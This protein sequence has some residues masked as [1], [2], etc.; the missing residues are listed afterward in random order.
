MPLYQYQA[1]DSQGR[2]KKGAIEATG[3]TD[4]KEKLRSQG[5]MVSNVSEQQAGGRANT[6]HGEELVLFTMQLSQLISAGLPLYESINTLEEQYRTERYHRVLLSLSEKVKAGSS[7]S[8][9][10]ADHPQSFDRLYCSMV[11]AGE[12]AGALAMVLDRLSKFLSTQLRLRQQIVT[13]MIYPAVLGGFAFLLIIG[14]LSFVVPML[15]EL[16]EGRELNQL[17]RFVLGASHVFVGYWWLLIIGTVGSITGLYFWFRSDQGKRLTERTLMRTP[18]VG[19]LMI[20]AALSRFARTMATLLEGGI[21]LVEA[22]RLGRGVLRNQ[23]LEQ[24]IQEA[25]AR[26]VEGA[27]LSQ[28]LK[29]VKQFPPLVPRLIAVAEDTGESAKMWSNIAD[30]FEGELE[31]NLSRVVALAQPVILVFMGFTIGLILLGIL[32]PLSD[33]SALTKG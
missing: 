2:S 21:T 24:R 30:I 15:E 29:R 4:A 3:L 27:T 13:S 5:L 7:L 22:L 18:I 17:T 8:A 31:K 20:R 33:I 32:L 25:E 11:A 19:S 12:A 1:F 26:V 16:L 6:L 14:M 23:Q 28:E 10:M 9:A